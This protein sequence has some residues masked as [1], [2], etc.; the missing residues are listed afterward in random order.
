MIVTI[1]KIHTNLQSQFSFMAP[2]IIKVITTATSIAKI[3]KARINRNI[4]L[5]II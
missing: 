1:A 4:V 2:P 5:F 3:A